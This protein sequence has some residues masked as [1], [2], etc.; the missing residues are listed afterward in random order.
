VRWL[1]DDL[2]YPGSSS[3][4]WGLERWRAATGTIEIL[5]PGAGSPQTGDDSWL[6]Y[7]NPDTGEMSKADAENGNKKVIGRSNLERLTPDGLQL[8]GIRT[9]PG[10]PPALYIRS[11]GGNDAR[12]ITTDR[13]RASANASVSPN[14]KLI[15]YPAFGD[16]NQ[17][18]AVVCELPRCSS[19]RILPVP[20][21]RAWTPD[22]KG[23]AY[24]DPRTRADIWIQP[25]DG[26]APRRLTRFPSDGQEIW[27][28]AW[29]T[30]GRRLAVARA[31][32]KNNIVL[33]SGLRRPN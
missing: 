27:D 29:S 13:V 6:A 8:V 10:K 23:I 18:A 7:F 33:F 32:T 1:G 16:D 25:L 22:S 5:A 21:P 11:I 19:P 24:I 28:F 26:G 30:D 9:T 3:G 4:A 20:A 12:D 31:S 14:L 15:A 17:P 2:I